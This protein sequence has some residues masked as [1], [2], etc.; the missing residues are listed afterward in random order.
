M[1][2]TEVFCPSFQQQIC[3]ACPGL[4]YELSVYQTQKFAQAMALLP[5]PAETYTP[6]SAEVFSS[7]T[8][9]KYAINE[10]SVTG[11]A[12]LAIP[13]GRLNYASISDCPLN[14]RQLVS[15]AQF[16]EIHIGDI[17]LTPY[18]L[19][20]RRGEWKYLHLTIAP[21]GEVM[22][23]FVLRSRE[24]RERLIKWIHQSLLVQSPMI[25]VVAINYLPEHQARIE[26]EEEEMVGPNQFLTFVMDERYFLAGPKSFVQSSFPLARELYTTSK[27]WLAQ[28]SCD[29]LFDWFCG[30]GSF[31][32]LSAPE[33]MKVFG[34]EISKQAVELANQAAINQGKKALCQY[35]CAD[36][37]SALTYQSLEFNWATSCFLA[38]PPRRGLGE[39]A[40]AFLL[41]H[42][43]QYI[44]YSSCLPESMGHDLES[45]K[46]CYQINKLKLFD[47]FPYS[48]HLEALMLL[49]KK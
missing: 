4:S 30:P 37:Y 6:S 29:T 34:V 42:R 23:K 10:D 2:D 46:S 26:G 33:S 45:L 25:K 44:L 36:A 24:A 7:R 13:Q 1:T 38:N 18:N 49:E 41:K 16:I 39:Q 9:V 15:I 12:R 21:N 43:P 27:L 31:S 11:K 8:R 17:A 20:T 35:L 5:Y 48:P 19:Q 14:H 28:L 40:I 3:T 47:L 22:I 32:L